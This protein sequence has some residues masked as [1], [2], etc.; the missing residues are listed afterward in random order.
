MFWLFKQAA[1][2]LIGCDRAA[3]THAGALQPSIKNFFFF[4]LNFV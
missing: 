3:K 1:V 2:D 4:H